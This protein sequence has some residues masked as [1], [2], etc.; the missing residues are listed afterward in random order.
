MI[1][2]DL[3]FLN[4]LESAPPLLETVNNGN[5]LIFVDEIPLSFVLWHSGLVYNGEEIALIILYT[6]YAT[7]SAFEIVS[8]HFL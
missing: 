5:E 6:Q 4:S 7:N 2:E 8:L 1:N 3:Y